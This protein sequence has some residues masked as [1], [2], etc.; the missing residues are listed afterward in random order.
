MPSHRCIEIDGRNFLIRDDFRGQGVASRDSLIRIFRL[1]IVSDAFTIAQWS[2]RCPNQPGLRRMPA[3]GF[4]EFGECLSILRLAMLP[5]VHAVVE[6]NDIELRA[7]ENQ[8]DFFEQRRVGH[9]T[10]GGKARHEGLS[11]ETLFDFVVVV[12]RNGIAD[13]Q[14]AREARFV[15]VGNPDV[16][17]LNGF[18]GGRRDVRFS[19]CNTARKSSRQAES[20][21]TILCQQP[22]ETVYSGTNNT[23]SY[24]HDAFVRLQAR[25]GSSSP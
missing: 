18:T 19:G 20:Q 4:D 6:D 23:F 11:S 13:E 8:L 25:A 1:R 9:E 16:A 24:V 21:Y 5:A 17:P 15:R 2:C 7:F 14:D 10:G 3:N 12:A 22:A